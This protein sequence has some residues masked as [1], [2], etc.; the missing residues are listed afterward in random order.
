VGNALSELAALQHNRGLIDDPTSFARDADA[1]SWLYL[2]GEAFATMDGGMSYSDVKAAV[3]RSTNI[4][5]DPPVEMTMIVSNRWVWV[6]L[7][8]AAH[9]TSPLR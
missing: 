3:D 9:F 5:S 2:C 8:H 4:V 7:H 6:V 1:A